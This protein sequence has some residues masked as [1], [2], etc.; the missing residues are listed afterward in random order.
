[1][2][3]KVVILCTLVSRSCRLWFA[4]LYPV[5]QDYKVLYKSWCCCLRFHS[6][7]ISQSFCLFEYI[8][9]SL[10]SWTS[11]TVNLIFIAVNIVL[12]ETKNQIQSIKN[13]TPLII[14]P[15]DDVGKQELWSLST[16]Y[17]N[18]LMVASSKAGFC[19]WEECV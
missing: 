5:V 11:Q 10:N 1:M 17:W 8:W 18:S 13:F 12:I 3:S 2:W 16:H 4:V 19:L 6:N 15:V 14:A 7:V 9:F